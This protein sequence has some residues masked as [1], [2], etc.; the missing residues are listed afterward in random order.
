MEQ[1]SRSLQTERNNLKQEIKN[2]EERLLATTQSQE[3]VVAGVEE[4]PLVEPQPVSDEKP[5]ADDTP[6]S[7]EEINS[8]E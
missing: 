6:Q 7:T 2:L 1:L 4:A 8:I 3:Q 5:K